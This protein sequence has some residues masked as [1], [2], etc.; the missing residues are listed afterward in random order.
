MHAPRCSKESR[1]RPRAA[2]ARPVRD[3][4][5]LRD[6]QLGLERRRRRRV[7]VG[8]EDHDVEAGAHPPHRELR[9]AQVHRQ[10]RRHP[11]RHRRQDRRPG[12]EAPRAQPR[13]RPAGPGVG[14][15]DQAARVTRCLLALVVALLLTLPAA[16]SAAPPS[17][18]SAR[19]AI[20]V[21][22][23]DGTAMF[24][25]APDERHSIASTTKLMTALLTLE[26]ARPNEVFTAPAY[27]AGAAESRINLAT[28]ER[29]RVKDLLQALLLESANDAAETLADNIGGSRAAFVGLMNTRASELGLAH[30]SYANP[31]GLDDPENY[32]T[33]RDLSSL[34]VRLLRKPRFARI[35]DTPEAVLES[36]SHRRVIDN[37]NDLVARYPFVDGVKTGHTTDAGYVLVGAARKSGGVSVVSVV[38]GEPS[39]AA[40]DTDT[41]TLLRWGLGRF[42]RRQ[43]LSPQRVLVRP[44]VKY[45]DESAAL[46]PRTPLELTVRRGERISRRIS[47]P[48]E[49]EGP[50][51]AGERVG[52]VTV[53]VDGKPV[54][55][56]A[57]VTAGKVPGAGALRVFFSSVGV[58]LTL[59]MLICAL[60]G[61]AVIVRRSRVRGQTVRE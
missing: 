51:S 27:S 60:A 19:A 4:H 7:V 6:R 34:A 52:L 38:L 1:P 12:G 37:R 18:D 41:L 36:G 13:A 25:K 45:R 24:Q 31:I 14:A 46:V 35:V 3:R 58:P 20:V 21:D 59:L 9:Q 11:R 15:E 43:V 47:V 44:S 5:P 42:H 10:D 32:S 57:L 29:M 26:R 56:V 61:G 55:R 40:R 17:V 2:R 23:G 48:D 50:L 30:T 28:G 16:A 22:G 39:E 54:R 8:R 33:A 53:L 49:V